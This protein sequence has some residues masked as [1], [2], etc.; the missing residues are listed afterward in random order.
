MKIHGIFKIIYRSL[1]WSKFLQNRWT[2]IG[3]TC[4]WSLTALSLS[5][6]HCLILFFFQSAVA[7]RKSH[8]L[9]I[10]LFYWITF[11]NLRILT[12]PLVSVTAIVEPPLLLHHDGELH[13]SMMLQLGDL[14][15]GSGR[16]SPRCDFE[17]HG[18]TEHT[19]LGDLTKPWCLGIVNYQ[20]TDISCIIWVWWLLLVGASLSV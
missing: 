15:N 5:S 10:I 8:S 2:R 1:F 20:E 18:S 3:D 13:G 19:H 9:V 11:P 16:A 6:W 14:A 12:Q 4:F 17:W 7:S